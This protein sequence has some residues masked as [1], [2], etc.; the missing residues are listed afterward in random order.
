MCACVTGYSDDGLPE[1]Q[2]SIK[3]KV[4]FSNKILRTPANM[5]E[6]IRN[7]LLDLKSFDGRCD[8]GLC[9][10]VCCIKCI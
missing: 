10:P 9:Q 1:H 4:L 6:D 3:W 7:V 5:H 2:L 8:Y